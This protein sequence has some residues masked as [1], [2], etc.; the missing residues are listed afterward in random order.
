MRQRDLRHSLRFE[1]Q[2]S[3]DVESTTCSKGWSDH[4]KFRRVLWTRVRKLSGI[5]RPRSRH[6]TQGPRAG[7]ASGASGFIY[8]LMTCLCFPSFLVWISVAPPPPGKPHAPSSSCRGV[9]EQG[10]QKLF[11]TRYCQNHVSASPSVYKK[12]K[13]KTEKNCASP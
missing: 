4:G 5:L 6:S 8:F 7:L 3:A 10:T 1:K 12:T 2:M 11:S 13:T 9:N